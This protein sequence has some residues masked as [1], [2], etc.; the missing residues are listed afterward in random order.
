VK[1]SRPAGPRRDERRPTK[2]RSGPS[3]DPRLATELGG[4]R[5][6]QSWELTPSIHTPVLDPTARQRW[7]TLERM[8]QPY[9]R[10]ALVLSDDPIALDLHCGEGWIAQRLLEWGAG[11]VVAFDDRPDSVR[12]AGLLRDHYAISAAELDVRLADETGPRD[13]EGRFDVVVLTGAADRLDAAGGL[14]SFA[15]AKTGSICAIECNGADANAVAEAA[16][17]AGFAAVERASQPLH[18]APCYVLGHRELLIAKAAI[19]G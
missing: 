4:E 1:T 2:A 6:E 16:L 5:W 19:G 12:R 18:G 9:A 8:L 13:V 14:P 7:W 11:R 10:D 15:R 17:A 3:L